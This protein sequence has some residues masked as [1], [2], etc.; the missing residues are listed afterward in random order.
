MCEVT[1]DEL[2]DLV[3]DAQASVIRTLDEATDWSAV[4]ADIHQQGR[5]RTD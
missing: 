3:A 4:V 1:W 5:T 2:D